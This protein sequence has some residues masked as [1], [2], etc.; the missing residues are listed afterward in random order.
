MTV[1]DTQNK[2]KAVRVTGLKCDWIGNDEFAR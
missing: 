1:M 2:D